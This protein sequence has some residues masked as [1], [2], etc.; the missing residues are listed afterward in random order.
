LS[1]QEHFKDGFVVSTDP[2]KLQGEEIFAFLSRSYWAENRSRERV[3][4]SL[5]NSL[6]F[7]L[8]KEGR[9]IGLARVVT[10]Y[11]TFAY[12]CDVYVLEEYRRRG[13]GKWLVSIVM[14]H[15]DLQGFRLW[16]LRTRDTHEL[17]RRFGFTELRFP[18][19]WMEK[20]DPTK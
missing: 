20:V 17:Y 5:K 11:S 16:S 18:D 9:Q 12:F 3:A 15:P 2:K 7:G 1:I 8:Y 14:D 6:C 19:R 13:L 4:L 10:D